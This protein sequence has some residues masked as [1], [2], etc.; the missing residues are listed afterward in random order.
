MKNKRILIGSII[1]IVI[2]AIFIFLLTNKN[3]DK[4]VIEEVDSIG[5]LKEID[6]KEEIDVKEEISKDVDAIKENRVITDVE[7]S[8]NNNIGLDLN[9]LI[10]APEN[11]TSDVVV[12]ETNNS[13]SYDPITEP[14]NMD[15]KDNEIS[16]SVT[17]SPTTPPKK[18]EPT[19]VTVD[20]ASYEKIEGLDYKI[21]RNE[22]KGT[23]A[24]FDILTTKKLGN[25]DIN[26]VG[27]KVFSLH[28][29]NNS[30]SNLA[31][32][33]FDSEESFRE[34]LASTYKNNPLTG[35]LNSYLLKRSDSKNKV[36]YKTYHSVKANNDYEFDLAN[37]KVKDA[38]NN[39]GMVTLHATL[40]D[41]SENVVLN[42]GKGLFAIV[43]ELNSGV[44]SVET[45]FYIDDVAYD[46]KSGWWTYN[47]VYPNFLIEVTVFEY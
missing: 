47:S 33:V 44:T 1:G 14:T 9:K 38:K 34:T 17:I 16:P 19:I 6:S 22:V 2:V 29:K 10:N 40:D 20:E 12:D 31:F 27:K 8:H 36:T 21:L 41:L 13:T 39:K 46:Y 23:T 15:N 42:T 26:A 18:T 32:N 24:Y 28:S 11:G 3:D 35:M 45:H 5:N 30:V 7:N 25:E 37:Y 4:K 43:K